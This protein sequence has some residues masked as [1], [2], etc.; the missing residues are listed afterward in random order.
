MNRKNKDLF[1]QTKNQRKTT[2]MNTKQLHRSLLT[3]VACALLGGTLLVPANA[4][5][6]TAAKKSS[7]KTTKT[8]SAKLWECQ[9]CKEP[10]SYAAAKEKSFKCCGMKMVEVKSAKKTE[11]KG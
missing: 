8:A 4:Q 10:M 6:K 9:H 2:T 3:L 11:K 7:K 1:T 5:N